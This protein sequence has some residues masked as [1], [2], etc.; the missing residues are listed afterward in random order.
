MKENTLRKLESYG[1]SIWLDYIQRHLIESGGLQRLIDE[2]G[3]GGVTSN[4]SIFDKAIEGSDDYDDAIRTL[5]HYGRSVEEIYQALTT[6][7]VGRAAD[8]F[9]P[10]YDRLQGRDGFVSIEVNPHL[11]RDVQGT[12]DAA[13]RL[14]KILSRPNVLVKVPATM[15][16]LQCIRQLISEGIN[17]NVTLLFGLPRY[18]MVAEA[19]VS[20]LEDR[21]AKGLPIENIASVA[22]FFLSRIDILMDHMLE[23]SSVDDAKRLRGQIAISSARIA[24]QTYK[25]IFGSERFRKLAYRGAQTQRVLW[26]ST[27]TKNPEY[28]DTKYVEAL[29][30][31]DT[32]NTLPPE[33]LEAYRDHGNPAPRLEDNLEEAY[34]NL[35]RLAGLG[36]DIDKITQQLEDEGIEKF[37]KPYDSLMSNLEE[38]RNSACLTEAG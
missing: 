3:L 20:G 25:T 21:A 28:P 19:Y 36:I 8:I 14:W 13:R 17:I 18:R 4:P 27:S 12:N 32:I 6:E 7:D 15:E 16:G 31:S 30:G 2:D 33:T 1:Q 26:A 29:I 24:Y 34:K 35:D 37:N 22:S 9:K 10:T 5:A 38:K 23:N 11:A